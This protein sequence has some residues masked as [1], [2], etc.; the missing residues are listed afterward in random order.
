MSPRSPTASAGNAYRRRRNQPGKDRSPPVRHAR[1]Q[2]LGTVTRQTFH[3]G[4]VPMTPR[5][6]GPRQQFCSRT[7]PC[8]GKGRNLLPG[9]P[10]NPAEADPS[11]VSSLVLGVRAGIKR[12]P[13]HV[14][15][16]S[17]PLGA[18]DAM[19]EATS[20]ASMGCTCRAMVWGERRNSTSA[21]RETRASAWEV[22]E[23]EA[24]HDPTRGQP[25]L[26]VANIP[27]RHALGEY[28]DDADYPQPVPFLGRRFCMCVNDCT[29]ASCEWRDL[30]HEAKSRRS[31]EAHLTNS[32]P[33]RFAIN[34]L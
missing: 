11:I 28:R 15:I 1:P 12:P 25:R 27:T 33:V 7:H 8:F 5:A 22:K 10:R 30:R 29:S 31:R 20:A 32:T 13:R 4:R 3:D 9:G 14:S 18:R 16:V 34:R 24:R 23:S 21:G 2:L 17:I 26:C 6:R 19:N